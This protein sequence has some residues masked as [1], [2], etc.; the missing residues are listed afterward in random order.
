MSLALRMLLSSIPWLGVCF[1]REFKIPNSFYM[2]LERVLAV[3]MLVVAVC[4]ALDISVAGS[5]TFTVYDGASALGSA[6]SPPVATN[7][8]ELCLEQC[9]GL[10]DCIAAAFDQTTS[11]CVPLATVALLSWSAANSTFGAVKGGVVWS[12]A[13]MPS[14]DSLPWIDGPVM[15]FSNAAANVYNGSLIW[16]SS[17]WPNENDYPLV[18]AD[19]VLVC[20]FAYPQGNSCASLN[21]ISGDLLWNVSLNSIGPMLYTTATSGNLLVETEFSESGGDTISLLSL[22]AAKGDV[23]WNV[24]VSLG[25]YVLGVRDLAI[26]NSFWSPNE[27]AAGVL[28]VNTSTGLTEWT[29]VFPSENWTAADGAPYA[30]AFIDDTVVV[31]N[32]RGSRVLHGLDP[33]TGRLL[34]RKELADGSC[35][36]STGLIRVASNVAVV[37][38][39]SSVWGVNATD[40][41]TLWRFEDAQ[42]CGGGSVTLLPPVYTQLLFTRGGEY[43]YCAQ[44]YIV[45]LH[46]G[47]LVAIHTDPDGCPFQIFAAA[48]RLVV[49]HLTFVVTRNVTDLALL[50]NYST[51]TMQEQTVDSM[52]VSPDATMLLC[53]LSGV[54]TI[55]SVW[56]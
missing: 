37:V 41:S 6:A 21:R 22:S 9:A 10:P 30:A 25:W 23:L 4:R 42:L 45:D 33:S 34:W 2:R 54:P 44:Q 31:V 17:I 16:S 32:F 27:T 12:G 56:L 35:T 48:G 26:L 19:A 11:V 5:S 51:P 15:Y 13:P 3:S 55:V 18:E 50:W 43:P 52:M 20:G 47:E 53:L 14:L 40:G 28:A 38:T 24:S 39:A 46:S 36:V 8:F 1:A 7:T 49:S 29:A